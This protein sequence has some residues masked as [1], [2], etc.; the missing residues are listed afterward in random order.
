MSKEVVQ[1]PMCKGLQDE[2]DCLFA[3]VRKV[4]GDKT[5]VCCCE[6]QAKKVKNE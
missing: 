5:I 4:E 2:G 1:C 6:T 3:T